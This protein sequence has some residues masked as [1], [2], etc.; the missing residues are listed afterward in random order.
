MLTGIAAFAVLL[1]LWGRLFPS[2]LDTISTG[3]NLILSLTGLR[4]SVELHPLVFQSKNWI[5]VY[6]GMYY[7][8]QTH[9]FGFEIEVLQTHI[10]MFLALVVATR[11]RTPLLLRAAAVG[12]VTLSAIAVAFVLL[13]LFWSFMSMP[14]YIPYSPVHPTRTVVMIVDFFYYTTHL[15]LVH[16]VPALLW[17]LTC[18]RLEEL[19]AFLS[20]VRGGEKKVPPR[21]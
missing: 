6:S 20:P 7:G 1:W 4:G 2:Y 5:A 3:A 12:L 14:E 10:P 9:L 17:G 18:F 8:K 15:L 21:R 11:K 16:L 13:T 19:A